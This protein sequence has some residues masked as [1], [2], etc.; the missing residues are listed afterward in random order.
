MGPMGPM[1]FM[2]GMGDCF[3]PREPNAIGP[4]AQL[5]TVRI[6]VGRYQASYGFIQQS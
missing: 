5:L 4:D 3:P 1:G 6:G 2:G